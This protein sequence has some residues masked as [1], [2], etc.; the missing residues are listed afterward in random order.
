M[1]RRDFL[2]TS[3]AYFTLSTLFTIDL[4]AEGTKS[5]DKHNRPNILWI[6]CEDTSPI[7]AVTVTIM[8][9][10]QISTG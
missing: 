5:C 8:L 4:Y 1:N 7:W 10:H 9:I 3:S 6:S 2:K